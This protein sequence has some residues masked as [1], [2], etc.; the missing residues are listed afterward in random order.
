MDVGADCIDNEPILEGYE[1]ILK[2]DEAYFRVIVEDF[3]LV[4]HIFV[5]T[6]NSDHLAHLGRLHSCR[7][8]EGL[9]PEVELLTIVALFVEVDIE[10]AVVWLRDAKDR[11]VGIHLAGVS[12]AFYQLCL[13]AYP[14]YPV[15]FDLSI[16]DCIDA[17]VADKSQL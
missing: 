14:A 1:F 9:H 12:H 4:L 10:G 2:L 13:L 7:I 5:Q 6:V 17:R 3:Y 16:E 8:D 15:V 11:H